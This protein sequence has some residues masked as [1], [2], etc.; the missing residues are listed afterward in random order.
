MKIHL[1]EVSEDCAKAV[2]EMKAGKHVILTEDGV[3][4]ALIQPLR[5]ATE[6]E[7]TAIQEMI[8]AGL[9][10]PGRRSGALREWKWKSKSARSSAA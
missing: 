2:E 1:Q 8:D 4:L 7:E 5:P 9:L 10:Q 3:A 6:D